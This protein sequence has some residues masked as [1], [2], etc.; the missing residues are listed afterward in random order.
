MALERSLKMISKDDDDQVTTTFAHA[1]P[2]ASYTVLNTAM[3][4]LNDL[5]NNSY[6]DTY[7]IDT[8]SLNSLVLE[9]D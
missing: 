2:N 6:V 7:V 5:S 3:R 1:N 8:Q 9:G 4:K